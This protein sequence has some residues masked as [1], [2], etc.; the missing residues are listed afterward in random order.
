MN[1][2]GLSYGCLWFAYGLFTL[3]F[4]GIFGYYIEWFL[5]ETMGLLNEFEHTSDFKDCNARICQM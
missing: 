2:I 5:S 1:Y 4:S 3:L